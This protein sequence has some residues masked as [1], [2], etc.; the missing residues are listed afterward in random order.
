MS[1]FKP[2]IPIAIS[3]GYVID[4]VLDLYT[5]VQVDDRPFLLYG[6]LYKPDLEAINRQEEA[7]VYYFV[8]SY[9][10]CVQFLNNQTPI[11]LRT[12]T[13]AKFLDLL[14]E[15]I[16]GSKIVSMYDFKGPEGA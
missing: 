3:S 14:A 13:R 11:L 4:E 7:P 5:V 15:S 10:A 9:T 2:L 8:G 12:T 6:I 16:D 1:L